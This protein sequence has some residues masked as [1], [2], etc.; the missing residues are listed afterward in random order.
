M[1][2]SVATAFNG[3]DFEVAWKSSAE[4]WNEAPNAPIDIISESDVTYYSLTALCRFN[5]KADNFN[6]TNENHVRTAI[7]TEGI[8][9]LFSQKQSEVLIQITTVSNHK[10]FDG[11]SR[12]VVFRWYFSD[13]FSEVRNSMDIGVHNSCGCYFGCNSGCIA[14]FDLPQ[15]QLQ[16]ICRSVINQ[17]S[18]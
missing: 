3:F 13:K 4:V 15:I 11:K 14:Y 1:L 9:K 12:T 6:K 16:N 8:L 17:R 2:V 7:E 10:D 18:Y 5:H